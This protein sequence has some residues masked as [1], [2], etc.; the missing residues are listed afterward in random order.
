[1]NTRDAGRLGWAMAATCLVGCGI[2]LGLGM[3]GLMM[4]IHWSGRGGL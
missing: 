1:M 4:L 3:L 2:V